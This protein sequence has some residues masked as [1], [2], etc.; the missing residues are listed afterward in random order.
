L[1]VARIL[2][3][4]AVAFTLGNALWAAWDQDITYDE[5]F[6]LSWPE[7]LLEER[8]DVRDQFRLDSKTPALLPA[9][10]LRR[11]L[12]GAGVRSPRILTFA[13][14]LQSLA[15]LALVLGLVFQL[16]STPNPHTRWI[17]LLLA[18][19]DPNLAAHATIATTDVA[20]SAV[21]LLFAWA[22]TAAF[23]STV[24][25]VLIGAVLG[26]GLATKYTAVLLAP[27]ALLV[28][29]LRGPSSGPERFKRFCVGL[30]SC[31][32]VMDCLYLWVGVLKPLGSVAFLTPMMTN[33]AATFPS[34]PLPIPPSVLTGIDASMAHN[35]PTLWASYMFGEEHRGGVWYYFIAHWLIK[36]PISLIVAVLL[37]TW[38]VSR[39]G[40]DA[41]FITLAAIALL[42]LV[43]FSFFFATQIGLRFAL[44]CIALACALAGRGLS[45][46]SP[47]WLIVLTVTSLLERAPY[48]GDPLAFTNLVVWEKS[49]AYWY[50]ADSNLDYGQNRDR[51]QRSAKDLGQALVMDQATIT[52]GLYV[53]SANQIAIFDSRR[54]HRWLIENDI[55]STR[56]GFTHFAFSITGDRFEQ[57]LD[58]AR[59]AT[60]ITSS[61]RICDPPVT[62]YPPGGQAP[63][64]Q[65]VSPER[66]RLWVICASSR[67]GAD[68]G[69]TVTSGRLW[70]G[71]VTADGGCEADLL[72]ERQQA[73]FRIPRGAAARLC[74]SEIP[75]RRA[76][77]P[78][79]TAGYLTIRGQGADVEFRPVP[80]AALRLNAPKP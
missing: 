31:I 20:Y 37:G 73:W 14:R 35:S 78:Y 64:E 66:G 54:S 39:K 29:I 2:A 76:S 44:P 38:H 79:L 12:D 67:K 49:R 65:T 77:L 80:L 30:M 60:P 46:I 72:Q 70:F 56:V 25:A 6:H 57:Y 19:L 10:L 11:A 42:H 22:A 27:A 13:T 63:F 55:P 26:V 41:V 3:L 43:Y 51:V 69:F 32:L 24:G 4:T 28:A 71:R 17:G 5:P 48:F 36:T 53:A 75:F 33:V 61:D 23:T 47:A 8:M 9:V 40:R 74:L 59:T 1:R 50:T 7:R 68:L 34:L 21:V 58:A 18:A 16:A 52:P 62:H 45:G 15:L